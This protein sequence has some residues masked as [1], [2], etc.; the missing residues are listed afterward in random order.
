MKY[1]YLYNI[2][3]L[4]ILIPN[5]SY[6]YE[7]NTHA[8]ITEKVYVKSALNDHIFINELG[9][10]ERLLIGGNDKDN[11]YFYYE[12]MKDNIY[13]R[14]VFAETMDIMPNFS[15]TPYNYFNPMGWFIRGAIREDDWNVPDDP[16]NPAGEATISSLFRMANHFW[17]PVHN[18]PLDTKFNLLHLFDISI[19]GK[20]APMWGLGALDPFSK[21]N[22]P[23][24]DRQNHFTVFDAREAMFRAVTGLGWD[25]TKNIIDKVGRSSGGMNDGTNVEGTPRKA[26][27]QDRLA[28][29]ATTFRALGDVTHLVEDM[30]QPEHTRVDRHS[31]FDSE[32]KQYFE[33]YTNRRAKERRFREFDKVSRTSIPKTPEKLLYVTD[34][35]IP[36]IDQYSDLFHSGK[37]FG[38]NAV[39][40]GRGLADYS[41]REFFSIGT[42]LGD[43]V[44]SYPSNNPESYDHQEEF[45]NYVTVP[46]LDN[47][48]P[49]A[50]YKTVGVRSRYLRQ[51]VYDKQDSN[52]NAYQ[53]IKTVQSAWDK[54]ATI[55][56]YTLNE[57]A[58]ADRLELLIPR[59][60]AYGAAFV[61]YFFRGRMEI[62]PPA[63][64]VYAI[65]DHG[66]A[67][68]TIDGLPSA[69]SSGKIYGFNK[70]RLR[71]RNTS[72]DDEA[73]PNGQVMAVVK[74]HLNRCYQPDLSGEHRVIAGV[75]TDPVHGPDSADCKN[76]DTDFWGGEEYIAVSLPQAMSIERSFKEIEF[77]FPDN[78]TIPVNAHSVYLQVVYRGKLG[79]EDDAVVVAT[80]DIPEPS[81]FMIAN[82]TD[83][84]CLDDTFYPKSEVVTM[85]EQ[86]L[87]DSSANG[88]TPYSETALKIAI[89]HGDLNSYT[90]TPFSFVIGGKALPSVTVKNPFAPGTYL[91][92]A[93]LAA[94]TGAGYGKFTAQANGVDM[95]VSDRQDLNMTPHWVA[96]AY[97]ENPG[98]LFYLGH[99]RGASFR[100]GFFLITNAAN[101]TIPAGS[102]Y[103]PGQ[104]T[105]M[106]D[107]DPVYPIAVT[108]APEPATVP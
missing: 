56:V 29:W 18:S 20:R 14:E 48:G 92:L 16:N 91:R 25:E 58:Y 12:N 85:I 8:R 107:F 59:A 81:Y 70:I 2:F 55:P 26:N 9:L 49:V 108:I 88:G 22:Q 46:D 35:T 53:R 94:D 47:G 72:A 68:N 80:R 90:Y 4:S 32:E 5:A 7:V 96:R 76:L 79:K 30:S 63:S 33:L 104:E 28:Y 89:A 74:Y 98:K 21:P 77:T 41:N 10:Y 50:T 67:H 3:L 84:Q 61:N 99:A 105:Q 38:D 65:I 83:Y 36:V 66:I 13:T 69:T 11:K 23:D 19:V 44:F 78:E 31:P 101:C 106:Q 97:G 60:V 102:P 87:I 40:T 15:K 86:E 27:E 42:N 82:N 51:T 100:T 37:A 39:L 1:V 95:P 6:S 64:G 75:K 52:Q 103:A 45:I 73:M 93:V 62:S 54:D 24:P 71:V 17:D 34:Y 57:A 43:N